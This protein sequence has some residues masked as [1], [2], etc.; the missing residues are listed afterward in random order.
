M[1]KLEAIQRWWACDLELWPIKNSFVRFSRGQILYSHQKLNVYM[2][3]IWERLQTPTTTTTTPD[4]TVQPLWDI[5][6]QGQRSV[7]SKTDRQTNRRTDR[8]D[9]LHIPFTTPAVI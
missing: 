6:N 8:L 4:A 3:L 7:G 2:V 9:R 1:Q 5:A